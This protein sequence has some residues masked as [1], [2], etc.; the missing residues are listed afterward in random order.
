MLTLVGLERWLATEI[1]QRYH[2]AEHRRLQ[3][4]TPVSAWAARADS[5]VRTLNADPE[6]ALRFQFRPTALDLL[7]RYWH[8]V[9]AAQRVAGFERARTARSTSSESQ[10]AAWPSTVYE[11]APITS[12][13][14]YSAEGNEKLWMYGKAGMLI[15]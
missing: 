4:T 14:I 9:A 12:N 1:A 7:H 10:A 6:A 3:S 15:T 2:K 8:P 5:S 11:S 13:T